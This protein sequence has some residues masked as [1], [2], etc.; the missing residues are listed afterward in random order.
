MINVG[1]KAPAFNA[2]AYINGNF[3]KISLADYTNQWVM[4]FSYPGDFTF[5]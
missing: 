1:K 5:V 4:L 2:Q 3:G